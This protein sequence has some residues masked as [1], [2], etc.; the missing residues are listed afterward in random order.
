M[1]NKRFPLLIYKTNT[2]KCLPTSSIRHKGS[3]NACGILKL[4]SSNSYTLKGGAA[5]CCNRHRRK[6]RWGESNGKRDLTLPKQSLN[7]GCACFRFLLL[8]RHYI[9]NVD[10]QAFRVTIQLGILSS[11]AENG[12]HTGKWCPG[13]GVVYLV[14]QKLD[15]GHRGLDFDTPALHTVGVFHAHLNWTTLVASLVWIIDATGLSL[16]KG[17]CSSQSVD[18]SNQLPPVW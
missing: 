11:R 12:F 18:E 8:D 14:G 7:K 13:E 3:L 4:P 6:M 2:D 9:R 16:Y 10:T 5:G 17:V 1:I 15:C